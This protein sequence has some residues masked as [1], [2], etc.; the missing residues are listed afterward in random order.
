MQLLTILAILIC[1]IVMSIM[2]WRMNRN[3]DGR[4]MHMKPDDSTHADHGIKKD[5]AAFKE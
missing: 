5:D 3:M 1:P 2:M 4:H